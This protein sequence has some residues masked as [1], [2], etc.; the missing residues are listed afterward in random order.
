MA[1]EYWCDNANTTRPSD[2]IQEDNTAF[3]PSDIAAPSVFTGASPLLLIS[4]ALLF[5]IVLI[6]SAAL[7][8]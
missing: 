4:P 6:A 1:D 8:I 7:L 2:L 5:V 3:S